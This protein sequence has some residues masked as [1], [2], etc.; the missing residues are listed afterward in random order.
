LGIGEPMIGRMLLYDA[1]EMSFT[2]IKI[3]KDPHCPVCGIPKEDVE[4]IDYEQFCGMPAHDRSEF[5][6]HNGGDEH[7]VVKEI[8]V[9]ELK[10][11][12]DSGEDLLVLDVRNPMEWEISALDD[13]LRIPKPDIEAATHDV[14]AGRKPREA[15]VL[16]QIP[17][18][19]EIIVHCRSGVRSADTITL[20]RQLGY[21]NKLLNLKGGILAWAEEIDPAMATY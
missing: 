15:T 18:D 4:L 20:L 6:K 17:D 13:T 8:T 10:S 7:D 21:K 2:T 11:R 14:L 12:L 3:R 1:L 9:Q 16:S 5:G 19:R